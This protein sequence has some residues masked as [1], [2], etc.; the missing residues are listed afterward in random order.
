MAKV[1]IFIYT[2]KRRRR[3]RRRRRRKIRELKVD[4]RIVPNSE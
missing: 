3:R 2:I 4:G 1:Y